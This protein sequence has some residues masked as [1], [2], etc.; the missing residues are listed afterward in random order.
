MSL[1]IQTKALCGSLYEVSVYFIKVTLV[2]DIVFQNSIS[3][4][5]PPWPALLLCQLRFIQYAN[6]S[7]GWSCDQQFP[8]TTIFAAIAL[9]INNHVK[10]ACAGLDFGQA[11]LQSGPALVP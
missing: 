8:K 11:R 5:T 3:R 6:A 10:T 1:Y 9:H 4:P 2:I 7:S